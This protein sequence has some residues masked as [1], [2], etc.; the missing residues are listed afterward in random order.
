MIRLIY[1][2]ERNSNISR[3]VYEKLFAYFEFSIKKFLMLTLCASIYF[4]LPMNY[5]IFGESKILI[6]KWINR[7]HCIVGELVRLEY[8]SD[9]LKYRVA[10]IRNRRSSEFRNHYP[11]SCRIF[12]ERIRL[13]ESRLIGDFTI[14]YSESNHVDRC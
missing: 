14:P 11:V 4:N 13:D 3:W 2:K 6:S 10:R 12:F 1:N 5:W 9:S 7:Y 8:R